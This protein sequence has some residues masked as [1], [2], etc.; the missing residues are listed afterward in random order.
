MKRGNGD[1]EK[2]PE[3]HQEKRVCAEST[4]KEEF[5]A[6]E[7]GSGI[8]IQVESAFLGERIIDTNLCILNRAIGT[9]ICPV[10]LEPFEDAWII[11]QTGITYTPQ[12]ILDLV[13]RADY[14]FV[15][16]VTRMELRQ[17]SCVRNLA[18][19]SDIF[20]DLGAK[21]IT[22]KPNPPDYRNLVPPPI[23]IPRYVQNIVID[24]LKKKEGAK[25]RLWNARVAIGA[26][27]GSWTQEV[28]KRGIEFCDMCY[29]GTLGPLLSRLSFKGM[30]FEGICLSK[31]DMTVVRADFSNTTWSRCS[32]PFKNLF[33]C[34]FRQA[35][36]VNC[37][38]DDN[39]RADEMVFA[40]TDFS[41]SKFVGCGLLW[42]D[43]ETMKSRGALGLE[44]VIWHEPRSASDYKRLRNI[45]TQ[46]HF[47]RLVRNGEF[48][49]GKSEDEIVEKLALLEKEEAE[50]LETVQEKYDDD[51][52]SISEQE[53][54]SGEIV[55]SEGES[56]F[57]EG[58]EEEEDGEEEEEEDDVLVLEEH[59]EDEE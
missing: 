10:T 16:P 38:L 49:H 50:F 9:P 58:E 32:I 1:M 12:V 53:I 7:L 4:E 29:T 27:D 59:R 37:Q 33:A 35:V 26:D 15:D 44:S 31:S 6:I 13:E 34:D 41:G 45:D 54:E 43:L 25:T 20:R 51:G 52:N 28:K 30:T 47:L 40:Q 21:R 57:G 48:S 22:L 55:G 11:V 24:A 46:K 2:D 42:R 14:V 56:M 36:F 5:W 3:S 17:I 23:E 8:S 39:Y 18:V 19:C